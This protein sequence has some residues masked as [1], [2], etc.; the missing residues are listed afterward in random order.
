MDNWYELEKKLVD[1]LSGFSS[2]KIMFR[3]SYQSIVGFPNSGFRSDGM[4]T[5]GNILIAIEVEAGQMHPDT[6][7][8]KYWYLEDEY[9]KYSKIILFHVY[10]PAFNSY[11]WRMRLASFYA[12]KMKESFPFD[13]RLFDYRKEEGFENVFRKLKLE[14]ELTLKQ[15]FGI[16]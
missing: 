9:K 1:W 6:N 8:G 13:Y 5:D 7:V 3:N 4:L 11:E 15:N 14:I 12:G 10:T 2:E 16:S